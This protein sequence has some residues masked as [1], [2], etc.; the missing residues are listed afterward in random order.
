MRRCFVALALVLAA[1]SATR[2]ELEPLARARVA[3]DYGSYSLRRVGVLPFVGETV[4]VEHGK[5][6]QRT[7]AAELVGHV[8][9]EV[10]QLDLADLEEVPRHDPLRRGRTKP[11]AVLELARRYRLDGVLVGTVTE[12]S[13]WPH[14]RAGIEVDLVAS[15][16]GMAIWSGR[17]HVDAA[18][19]ST[20]EHLER[21]L[22]DTRSTQAELEGADVWLMSPRRLVEFAAA[23]VAGL[24]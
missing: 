13:T 22:D 4:E 2:T 10:V 3:S 8:P 17:I 23:Q 21:W 7:F 5:A 9:F 6:L 18:Q 20:R 15:E 16:T 11:E 1:C 19:Q 12:L 14:A 24:L